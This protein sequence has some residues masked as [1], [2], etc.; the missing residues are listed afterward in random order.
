MENNQSS[1]QQQVIDE[2]QYEKIVV[3]LEQ[4]SNKSND[5]YETSQVQAAT[6]LYILVTILSIMIGNLFMAVF[7]ILK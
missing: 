3:L 5:I 4:Q 7:K 1:Q 6:L 2:S